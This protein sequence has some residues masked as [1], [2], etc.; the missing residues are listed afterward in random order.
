MKMLRA[1]LLLLLGGLGLACAGKVA[2][3]GNEDGGGAT[4]AGGTASSGGQLGGTSSGGA[5][6]EAGA[7]A[8]TGLLGGLGATSGSAPGGGSTSC[9]DV[10]CALPLCAGERA[11]TP[12]GACCPVC[13]GP[14]QGCE[15]VKCEPP[16]DC[17]EGYERSL[18]AG[19][20]CPGC[21]P[22]VPHGVS[23][24]EVACPETPC[25]PGYV[26]GDVL[27]GCCHECLPDPLYCTEDAD[28]VAA[29]KPRSCCGCAEVITRRQF[30]AEPCWWEVGHP[31][32]LPSS[33][34]PNVTCDAVCSPCSV[35]EVVACRGNRCV[36]SHY[37][38]K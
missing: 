15:G 30:A 22:Q 27:G 37:G 16:S 10:P 17:K 34:Y 35:P 13:S 23:C 19:A 7:S 4:G 5:R 1:P 26:R 33:C 18:A 12:P 32:S 25:Q 3:R 29:D 28:C 9:D 2:G 31:R 20:C 11:T 6:A 36:E 21:L 38:L 14:K 24:N 8:G